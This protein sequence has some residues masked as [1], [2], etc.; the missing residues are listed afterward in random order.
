MNPYARDPSSIRGAITPLV[1]PFHDDGELET[2]KAFLKRRAVRADCALAVERDV[3]GKGEPA[4]IAREDMLDGRGHTQ[5]EMLGVSNRETP[6]RAGAMQHQ[7]RGKI[8]P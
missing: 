1:T 3:V 8:V 6:F 4:V 5:L 7:L 2:C